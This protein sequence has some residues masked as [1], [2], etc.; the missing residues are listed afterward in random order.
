M[1]PV[2]GLVPPSATG[3]DDGSDR[4]EHEDERDTDDYR[5]NHDQELTQQAGATAPSQKPE[6]RFQAQ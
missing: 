2:F 5:T 4:G 6:P 1:R 3:C